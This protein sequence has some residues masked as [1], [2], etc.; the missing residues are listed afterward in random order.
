MSP[1]PFSGREATAFQPADRR[2]VDAVVQAPRRPARGTPR[3]AGRVPRALRRPSGAHHPR[4]REGRAVPGPAASTRA[5]V[6]VPGDGRAGRP[7]GRHEGRP[8][9]RRSIVAGPPCRLRSRNAPLLGGRDQRPLGPARP[10]RVDRAGG[11]ARPHGV[12]AAARR[13]LHDR[14]GAAALRRDRARDPAGR[15]ERGCRR[16]HHGGLARRAAPARR[17]G[18]GAPA[19]GPGPGALR[20]RHGPGAPPGR[21]RRRRARVARARLPAPPALPDPG[22]RPR[23]ALDDR[24]HARRLRVPERRRG[25]RGTGPAREVLRV[26]LLPAERAL[27]ARAGPALGLVDARAG[28]EP[29]ARRAAAAGAAGRARGRGGGRPGRSAAAQGLRRGTAALAQPRGSRAAVRA[30]ARR[31]AL[32]RQAGDRPARS[33]RRAGPGVRLHSGR[34]RVGRRQHHDRDRDGAA[35]PGLGRC[36]A[37]AAAPL[38]ER[39]PL[40]AP[41]RERCSTEG[42]F[43][44]STRARSKPPCRRSTAGTTEK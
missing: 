31:P 34:G 28:R 3:H 13:D 11:D 15:D 14:T 8:P 36:R 40:R 33:A 12:L 32:R 23:R 16:A 7:P 18:R 2:T 38:P 25:E 42:R 19:H 41:G 43:R 1:A 37:R 20:H 39:V 22:G 5:A 26:L 35:V 6:D 24:V 9:G 29:C 30:G 21:S 4:D 17:V 10:L 44:R 27:H